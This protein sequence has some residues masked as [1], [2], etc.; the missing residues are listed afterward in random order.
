M[1]A[2]IRPRLKKMMASIQQ[3]TSGLDMWHS[4]QRAISVFPPTSLDDLG[5]WFPKRRVALRCFSRGC[6]RCSEFDVE[7]RRSFE[8]QALRGIEVVID[9]DCSDE[10]QRAFAQKCGVTA[11]PAYILLSGREAGGPTVITPP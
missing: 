9:W 3:R 2:A 11:I 5:R 1:N 6:T 8:Y 10:P 7:E 4:T